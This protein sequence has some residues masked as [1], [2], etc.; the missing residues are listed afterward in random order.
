MA[1]PEFAGRI[2]F[3]TGAGGGIGANIARRLAAEGAHAVVA[4]IDM[5]AAQTVVDEIVGAGGAASAVACDTSEPEQ[6][7][8]AI[9]LTVVEHGGLHLAV[10]NAGIGG[11]RGLAADIDLSGWRRIIDVTL[12]GVFYGIHFQLPAMIASG[13]GAIVNVSSIFGLVGN[14]RSVPYTAAKHGV[15]GLTKAVALGYADRGVRVNSVHPGYIDTPALQ[16][17]DEEGR[18]SLVRLHPLGRLGLAEEVAEVVLFLLSERASFV[19]GSQFSVDGG[20][21]AQ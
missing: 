21:S 19:T 18:S 17:L 8:E 5:T 7:E 13:G 12:S 1:E 16:H 14:G 11:S 3:V 20:Y 10:N 6:V 15:T 9:R 2:A 4:D